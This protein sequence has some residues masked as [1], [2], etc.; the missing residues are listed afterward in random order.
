V[1]NIFLKPDEQVF[2]TAKCNH[3]PLGLKQFGCFEGGRGCTNQF[4]AWSG[5]S[6]PE[7]SV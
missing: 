4:G 5:Q 7:M 6:V 2:S 3:N 1:L